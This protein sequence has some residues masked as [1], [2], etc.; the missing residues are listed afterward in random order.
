M[1]RSMS[2]PHVWMEAH[3]YDFTPMPHSARPVPSPRSAGRPTRRRPGHRGSG[4]APTV[5]DLS[6]QIALP[7]HEVAE[8]LASDLRKSAVNG[9]GPRVQWPVH[10]VHDDVRAE[11]GLLGEAEGALQAALEGNDGRPLVLHV[12]AAV[13][14][15]RP[16]LHE[17]LPGAWEGVVHGADV[18]DVVR[19]SQNGHGVL[20]ESDEVGV[21]EGGQ[22]V[23]VDRRSRETN[24]ERSDGLVE[25]DVIPKLVEVQVEQHVAQHPALLHGHGIRFLHIVPDLCQLA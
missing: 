7:P 20:S 19:V 23:E 21:P 3:V 11:A 16:V 14:E 4:Q 10:I 13:G 2:R 15:V 25:L 22:E 6:L 17:G 8:T 12:D 18:I 5:G 24:L 9:A 1:N